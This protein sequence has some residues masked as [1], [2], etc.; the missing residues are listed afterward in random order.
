MHAHSKGGAIYVQ[1][2]ADEDT[3]A[4]FIPGKNSES[5]CLRDLIWNLIH[6]IMK[7]DKQ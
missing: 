6:D 2:S 3:Q 7:V 5:K 1:K 4:C